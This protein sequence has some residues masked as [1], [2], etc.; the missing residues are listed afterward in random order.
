MN[1]KFIF[2]GMLICLLAVGLVSCG[3]GS[4]RLAGVWELD[5]VE[6][7]P[8]WGI[9]QSF[10]FFRDGTGDLEGTSITWRTENNRLSIT[11]HGQVQTVDFIL[12]G[13]T[14]TLIYDRNTGHRAIYN[15]R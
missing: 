15:R 8:S 9:V 14:L 7:G 6:N 10:E 12:S 13:S 3:R 1:K 4:S 2:S 5:R 11:A